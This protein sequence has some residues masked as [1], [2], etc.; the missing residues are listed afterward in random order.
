MENKDKTAIEQP[1]SEEVID[2]SSGESIAEPEEVKNA[3]ASA[4]PMEYEQKNKI[5]YDTD[6]D[7]YISSDDTAVQKIS[8]IT[9]KE[10]DYDD[11]GF[12]NEFSNIPDSFFEDDIQ[13]DDDSESGS[14]NALLYDDDDNLSESKA[15]DDTTIS[16]SE[17]KAEIQR[18]KDEARD[19]HT[20]DAKTKEP[21]KEED[22]A[23][24]AEEESDFVES[25]EEYLSK[26]EKLDS[27]TSSKEY[28][29]KLSEEPTIS[30]EDEKSEDRNI[31][32]ENEVEK[33]AEKTI[34]EHIIRIDRGR[35]KHKETP[36]NRWIDRAFDFVET[37]VFALLAAMIVLTFFF[38]LTTVSGSSMEDTFYDGDKLIV[39]NL[40]Y[41]PKVGD[42]IV[43]DDRSKDY[44]EYGQSPIIK[45]VFAVSGETVDIKAGKI[46]VYTGNIEDNVIARYIYI[47]GIKDMEEPL[48]IEEGQIYVLGDNTYNSMDS[49]D[50]GTISVESILG[51]VILRYKSDGK[52]VFDT[53]FN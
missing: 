23:T 1:I 35:V 24:Q 2:S 31:I 6:G 47:N 30:K 33:E 32:T 49:R 36:T 38:R 37:V 41:T 29:A 11:L 8:N 42:V 5:D 48:Y 39:S 18:I 3:F 16:L 53:K 46:T 26:T 43:F 13:L 7:E 17:L 44:G 15:E 22:I 45:R 50:V 4:E 9:N 14:I 20:D 52:F 10:S 51:K 25:D 40:F 34:K 19:L 27:Y 12:E 21:E 28:I